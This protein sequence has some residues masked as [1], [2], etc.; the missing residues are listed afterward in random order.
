MR[1]NLRTCIVNAAYA[2]GCS[3]LLATTPQALPGCSR[4]DVVP[5]TYACGHSMPC[6]LADALQRCS[7]A[8]VSYGL[9]RL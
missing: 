8:A 2:T 1:I 7:N 4:A 6:G 5:L 9:R 3:F